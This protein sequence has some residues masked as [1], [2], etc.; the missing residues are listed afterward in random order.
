[1]FTNAEK[2][3]IEERET[4]R[5]EATIVRPLMAIAPMDEWK[6]VIDDQTVNVFNSRF[7]R[8]AT[9]VA[10]PLSLLRKIERKIRESGKIEFEAKGNRYL[11]SFNGNGIM[12]LANE[13]QDEARET[14]TERQT[15]ETG[16]EAT[17][18]KLRDVG[19]TADADNSR[20]T[21]GNDNDMAELHSQPKP[22]IGKE[23]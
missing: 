4:R 21:K 10:A 18:T 2:L 9:N 23:H 17:E 1:M 11:G 20:A 8:N 3:S 13:I 12:V 15:K 22:T 6:V 16:N 7:I 14:Q 5:Y 19:K